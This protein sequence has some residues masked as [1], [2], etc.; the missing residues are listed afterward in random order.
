MFTKMA[1]ILFFC[2]ALIFATRLT[3]QP[4]EHSIGI[5]AGYS[6]GVTYKGFFLH[7][8]A[9]IEGALLY[10]RHGFNISA[11]YEYHL[12]PFR[13]KRLLVYMGGG[14][15]AGNWEGELSAGV[16]PVA[17]IAYILRDLPLGFSADWKPMLNLVPR[18]EA[19]FV[20]FGITIRYRF[21]L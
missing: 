2:F 16:S 15:F 8:M 4:Y 6:S 3:A 21:K 14:P 11:M 13:K 19:D 20:D 5:R 9:G 17:G 7:R 12:E 10:N 18:P 1:R